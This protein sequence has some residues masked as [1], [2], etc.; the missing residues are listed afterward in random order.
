MWPICKSK[1]V[2]ARTRS[3]TGMTRTTL[4]SM[5]ILVILLLPWQV[6][7]LVS[8]LIHPRDLRNSPHFTVP[9]RRRTHSSA[10][11]LSPPE[12]RSQHPSPHDAEHVLLLLT[13]LLPNPAPGLAVWAR[14]LV[15]FGLGAAISSAGGD[16][17]ILLT[18]PYLVVADFASRTRD[19]LF[20]PQARC[21]P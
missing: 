13:W 12:P 4:L 14:T 1:R 19:A 15:T 2:L 11:P 3:E 18:A 9:T 6:A 21:C 17:N 16:H 5:F 8:G 10:I 20:P 7:F